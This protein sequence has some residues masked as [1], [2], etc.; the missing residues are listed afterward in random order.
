MLLIV[1]Q[2]PTE[3]QRSFLTAFSYAKLTNAGHRKLDA[4]RPG[5][6]GP[7]VSPRAGLDARRALDRRVGRKPAPFLA[8][9]AAPLANMAC[10]IAGLLATTSIMSS[11]GAAQQCFILWQ[12]LYKTPVDN[13]HG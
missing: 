9:R 8:L 10:A 6:D 4:T 3:R 5:L 1:T 2:K 7:R 13:W 12:V 11:H